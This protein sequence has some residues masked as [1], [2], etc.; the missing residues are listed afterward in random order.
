MFTCSTFILEGHFERK[1]CVEIFTLF[2]EA[3]RKSWSKLWSLWTSIRVL[4]NRLWFHD[5]PWFPQSNMV[6]TCSENQHLRISIS[7]ILGGAPFGTWDSDCRSLLRVSGADAGVCIQC[8]YFIYKVFQKWGYHQTDAEN[9]KS[10]WNGWWTGIAA[11]HFRTHPYFIIVRYCFAILL[12]A[13]QS[14]GVFGRYTYSNGT[15]KSQGENGQEWKRPRM[16]TRK[17]H[18]HRKDTVNVKGGKE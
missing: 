16:M 15:T 18:W 9:G 1:R 7:I 8:V 11:A 14:L 6:S 4:L 2:N 13:F 10:Y 3:S 12:P 5:I 17:K